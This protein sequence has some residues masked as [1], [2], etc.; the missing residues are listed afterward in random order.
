MPQRVGEK[1][2]LARDDHRGQEA[3]KRRHDEHGKERVFHKVHG[4]KFQMQRVA[5][6]IPEGH[7][8]LPPLM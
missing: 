2:H 3:K 4:Q 1:A 8:A 7:S 6:R 5:K